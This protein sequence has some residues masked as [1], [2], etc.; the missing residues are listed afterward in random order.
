MRVESGATIDQ[1]VERVFEY[2][3]M[4]EKDPNWVPVSLRH[5]RLSPGPM[6]VGSITERRT[7]SF[8]GSV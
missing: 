4:P 6:R 5:E 2:V 1:P 8:S 3:T 7:W